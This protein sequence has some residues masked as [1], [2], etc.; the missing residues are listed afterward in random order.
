MAG[1]RSVRDIVSIGD[2]RIVRAVIS[3]SVGSDLENTKLGLQYY[4]DTF[5]AKALTV[6][7]VIV[8]YCGDSSRMFQ[9]PAEPNPCE[10]ACEL[11]HRVA[12]GLVVVG[13]AVF[14]ARARPTEHRTGSCSACLK[15]QLLGLA[16]CHRS[17]ALCRQSASIQT[18]ESQAVGACMGSASSGSCSAC[19]HLY[20]MGWA[21]QTH[22]RVDTIGYPNKARCLHG[23]SEG[24][25]CLGFV[26][27]CGRGF[28]LG[29]LAEIPLTGRTVLEC[30]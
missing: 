25:S 11:G 27:L 1:P 18:P 13:G 15:A 28:F 22:E 24:G 7:K 30:W 16:S 2:C 4:L 14:V 23:Q 12:G 5:V 17:G 8:G 26:W 21:S 19:G 29:P 9:T 20:P 10:L 6:T 3:A